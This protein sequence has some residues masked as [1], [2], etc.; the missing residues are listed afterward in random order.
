[1]HFMHGAVSRNG[2]AAQRMYKELS[3]RATSQLLQ[4]PRSGLIKLLLE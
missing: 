4:V 1:M 3:F 2:T